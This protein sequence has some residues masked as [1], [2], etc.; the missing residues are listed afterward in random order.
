MA[1]CS[2]NPDLSISKGLTGD[3]KSI[4][5]T[6]KMFHFRQDDVRKTEY[7]VYLYSISPI[8]LKVVNHTIYRDILIPPCPEGTPYVRFLTVDHPKV[9]PLPN[10]NDPGGPDIP[11]F[12]N[13]KR[14]ALSVLDPSYFSAD[15]AEQ[16]LMPDQSQRLSSSN[17]N[18]ACRGCFASLN[19]VPTQAELDG[20]RAR[21]DNF[22]RA[23]I[24]DADSV[25]RSNPKTLQEVLTPDHHLAAERF[26]IDRS[27]HSQIL[28]RMSCPLCG[29]K[30][31]EG[32][33]GHSN[34]GIMCV[35][36]WE[37]A[38]LAGAVK[39]DAVPKAKRGAWWHS[40][41]TGDTEPS[42]TEEKRKPGRPIGS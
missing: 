24:A 33:W 4:I 27:W 1:T 30:I 18:L 31:S 13:G 22:H 36:D 17:M 42:T 11:H 38:Y 19:E 16:E 37:K 20:A 14:V 9:T 7:C 40:E 28:P 21:M 34:N 15:L 39:L 25:Q 3:G 35:N 29:E 41:T 26:G 8:P 32:A 23:C 2:L 5:Q 12:D 10:V 6:E